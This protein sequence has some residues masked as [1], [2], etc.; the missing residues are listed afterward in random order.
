MKNKENASLS[1]VKI[2]CVSIILVLISGIGVL[3]VKILLNLISFIFCYL[4]YYPVHR[5]VLLYHHIE[6]L[7][8]FSKSQKSLYQAFSSIIICLKCP[9]YNQ[10]SIFYFLYELNFLCIIVLSTISYQ[11]KY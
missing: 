11:I 10:K 5:I 6:I 7:S 3:A 9:K 2:I 8:N 4:I 1:I